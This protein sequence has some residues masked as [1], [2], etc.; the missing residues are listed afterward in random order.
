MLNATEMS[1]KQQASARMHF[2]DMGSL[3]RSAI[4]IGAQLI[5]AIFRYVL[6]KPIP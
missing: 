4:C 2:H 6:F 1:L 5:T 3:N